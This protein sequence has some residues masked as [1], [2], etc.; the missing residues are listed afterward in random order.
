ML[1]VLNNALGGSPHKRPE[2][3]FHA[4]P[5]SGSQEVRKHLLA[6]RQHVREAKEASSAVQQRI[7]RRRK[8]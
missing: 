2:L 6:S 5:D 3:A 8:A 7:D 4:L 1:E